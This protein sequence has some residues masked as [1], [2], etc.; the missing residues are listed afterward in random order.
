[1]EYGRALDVL[2]GLWK[3]AELLEERLW[4]I[5]CGRQKALDDWELGMGMGKVRCSV[6]RVWV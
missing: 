4:K 5:V 1:M 2:G 6:T 3:I